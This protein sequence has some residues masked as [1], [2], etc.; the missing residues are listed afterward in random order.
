M[1]RHALP[2]AV[3]SGRLRLAA[4]AQPLGMTASA[5]G[6]EAVQRGTVPLLVGIPAYVLVRAR[7]ASR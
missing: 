2:A 5:I 1:T 6:A 4:R 7:R 3:P